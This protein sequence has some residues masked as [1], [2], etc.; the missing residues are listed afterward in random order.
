MR[1]TKF[2]NKRKLHIKLMLQTDST[3]DIIVDRK[4]MVDLGAQQYRAATK[5]AGWIVE[6]D[7]EKVASC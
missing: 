1:K 2:I 7:F 3:G 6:R 4:G 5:V